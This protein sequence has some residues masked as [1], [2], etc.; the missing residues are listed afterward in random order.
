MIIVN[1]RFTGHGLERLDYG[2]IR[3]LV[4]SQLT[5]HHVLA[6]FVEV[7]HHSPDQSF[8]VTFSRVHFPTHFW[9]TIA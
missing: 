1:K 6:G 2:R 9:D 5:I 8:P 3:D 7:D 4:G